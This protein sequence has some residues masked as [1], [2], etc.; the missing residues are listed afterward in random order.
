MFL[1]LG[2]VHY[3]Y[4]RHWLLKLAGSASPI[5]VFDI[6]PDKVVGLCTVACVLQQFQFTRGGYKFVKE[7]HAARSDGTGARYF[8]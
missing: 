3:L 8:D 2:I 1:I 5:A 6:L 4:S 7:L